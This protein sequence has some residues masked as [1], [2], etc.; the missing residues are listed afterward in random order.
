MA[1]T[2][3][4]KGVRATHSTIALKL[5][6]AISGIVFIL[7][8]LAHMYGN[9][10]AFA[11]HDAYNEYAEHLRTLG[12]PMLPYAGFLWILRV[13]LLVALIVHVVSAV[14]LWKRAAAA[15]PV[16]Y[17]VKKNVASSISSRT[18]R[19]GGLTI[20]LFL[21]W[22]LLQFTIVKIDITDGSTG[23]QDPYN[24]LVGAFADQS[25]WM[26]VIYLL[27]MVALGLH[28]H[29]G[30]FSSLQTLGY[31]NTATSRARARIAGWI[32]AIVIAGGFSLVPLFA[33]FGVI[34]K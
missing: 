16:K 15:R 19:W 22:H 26:T 6:M 4:V 31:T 1:T 30:T 2:E 25:W 18:M 32:V 27:A 23:N 12:T 5:A 13:G 14:V 21:I 9:L 28:L 8:V 17:A 29:H 7:F 3:L 20:L 10:K 34:S 11:G 24:L 33:L